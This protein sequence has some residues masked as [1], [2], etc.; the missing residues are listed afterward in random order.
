MKVVNVHNREL[1]ATPS[2]AGVLIDGLASKNDPIWPGQEWP[3]IKFDRPLSVGA[4]GGHGPIRYFVEAYEPGKSILFRFTAPKGFVGTHEFRL[5]EITAGRVL[6]THS[7]KMDAFGPAML[8]W[9]LLIR[10][11]HDALVEDGF[12]LA[13]K[14]VGGTPK[15]RK[16]SPAVRLLRRAARLIFRGRT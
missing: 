10:P 15:P 4:A 8:T 2:E 6:L 13:E 7:I 3:P 11:L 16:W 14:F 5:D 9:P 1:A 12:D